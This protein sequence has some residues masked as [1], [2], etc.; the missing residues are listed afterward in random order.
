MR[1]R[2]QIIE[3][4]IV[5]R[6]KGAKIRLRFDKVVLR[7]VSRLQAALTNVVPD[8][9]AVIFTVAAPIRLPARTIAVLESLVRNIQPGEH[10]ELVHGNQVRFRRLTEVPQR[11]PKVLGFVHDPASDAG[12][13][14]DLAQARL[15]EGNRNTGRR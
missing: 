14:L 11:M 9:E 4:E 10:R 5:E 3:Q 1:A 12:L 13:I 7:L 2:F 8:G 6:I 15:F